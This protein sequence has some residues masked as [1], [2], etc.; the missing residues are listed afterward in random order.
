MAFEPGMHLPF[1]DP[2]AT[3]SLLHPVWDLRTMNTA[4]K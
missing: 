2:F 1:P 4:Q 3:P